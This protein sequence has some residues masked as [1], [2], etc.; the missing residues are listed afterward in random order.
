MSLH[1]QWIFDSWF[2]VPQSKL[3]H[4]SDRKLQTRKHRLIRILK[5]EKMRKLSRIV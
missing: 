1:Q 3:V 5:I 2:N 4:S